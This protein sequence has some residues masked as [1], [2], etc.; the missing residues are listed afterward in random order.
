[1]FPEDAHHSNLAFHFNLSMCFYRFSPLFYIFFCTSV[2]LK[3]GAV[4]CFVPT[5]FRFLQFC[6]SL[7]EMLFL[8]LNLTEK[9]DWD[10]CLLI[11]LKSEG[12]VIP[13]TNP[14]CS[15]LSAAFALSTSHLPYL[16]VKKRCLILRS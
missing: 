11:C 5:F 4:D 1:M 8:A 13:R 14:A 16:Y 10:N 12:I 9:I 7:N 2:I 15:L 3:H 6:F